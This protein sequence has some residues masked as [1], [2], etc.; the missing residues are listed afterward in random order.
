MSRDQLGVDQ[1]IPTEDQRRS[2][3]INQINCLATREERSHE[4]K[5]DQHPQRAEQVWHPAREVILRLARKQRQRNED[6][7]CDDQSLKH[8]PAF[9]E[10]RDHTDTVCLER[11]EAREKEHVGWVGLALPERQEHEANGAEER[12]PHHPLI[13]LDPCLV[14]L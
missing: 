1:N 11:R 7:Q 3:S 10:G 14:G 6:S 8:N 4:T 2:T 9:V 12:H 5:D 13:A